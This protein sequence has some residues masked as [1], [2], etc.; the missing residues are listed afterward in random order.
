[1]VLIEGENAAT[2]KEAFAKHIAPG[3]EIWSDGHKAFEWL[4]SDPRWSHQ[5]NVHAQ[6]EFSK[7]VR[8]PETGEVKLVST[9]SVEGTLVGAVSDPLKLP[10]YP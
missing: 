1:M 4:N 5:V 2:M 7:E 8:D 9:N 6:R 10:G 3:T